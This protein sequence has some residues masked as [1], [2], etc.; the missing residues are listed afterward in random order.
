MQSISKFR[1]IHDKQSP[2]IL[3]YDG[4][5]AVYNLNNADLFLF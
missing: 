4:R 2:V 5:N 1:Q 3:D